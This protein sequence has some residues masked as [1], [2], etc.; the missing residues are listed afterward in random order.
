[1]CPA[2]SAPARSGLNGRQV[3]GDGKMDVASESK[4]SDKTVC[5]QRRCGDALSSGRRRVTAC[6]GW[7]TLPDLGRLLTGVESS[8][9]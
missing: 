5:I 8:R 1:M 4:T 3:G 6:L 7:E 2:S 9:L